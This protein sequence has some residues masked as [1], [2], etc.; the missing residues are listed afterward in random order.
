[1]LW[2]TKMLIE[3]QGTTQAAATCQYPDKLT[4]RSVSSLIEEFNC[5]KILRMN[6]SSSLS[7]INSIIL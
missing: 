3:K 7:V 6:P 1:M 5:S 4:G 2:L